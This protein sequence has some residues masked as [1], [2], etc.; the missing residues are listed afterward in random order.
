MGFRQLDGPA[1]GQ[2]S[3]DNAGMRKALLGVLIAAGLFGQTPSGDPAFEVATIKPTALDWSGG[4]FIRTRTAHELEARNHA[5]K[6]L[7]AAAYDLSPQ[8]ISGV[9]DWGKSDHYD[10][11]AK[12][13]GEARPTLERQMAMLRRL[14][15]ERFHL[16]CHREPREMA[17]YSLTVANGGPKLREPATPADA[18][19]QGPPALAFV[20]S[21]GEA[22]LPARNATVGEF[23]SVLQRAVLTR[24]VIDQTGITGRYDFDL[25]FLP[26][27]GQFGRAEWKG[28]ANHPAPELFTAVKE[29]LGLKL[30]ATRGRVN[31][32]VVDKAEKP[33]GN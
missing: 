29:Q 28:E 14:L 12:A 10:I 2:K 31:T 9:P 25:E 32:L 7:L 30:E 11:V 18:L 27:E 4:R 5:L 17:I 19:P 22:G 26:D 23:A 21:S 3:T 13:P 24:P 33:S 8:A 20:I 6:T 1:W 15:N 16:V